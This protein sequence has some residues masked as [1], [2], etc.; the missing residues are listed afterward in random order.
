MQCII[1]WSHCAADQHHVVHVLVRLTSCYVMAVTLCMPC[2]A[3]RWTT[4]LLRV[5]L[6]LALLVLHMVVMARMGASLPFGSGLL[7]DVTRP[8]RALLNAGDRA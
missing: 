7:E 6:L 3:C 1:V 2:A 4:V 8:F 5:V